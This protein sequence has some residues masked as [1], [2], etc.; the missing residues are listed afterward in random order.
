[1]ARPTPARAVIT[2]NCRPLGRLS[3]GLPPRARGS[4]RSLRVESIARGRDLCV[5]GRSRGARRSVPLGAVMAYPRARGHQLTPRPSNLVTPAPPLPPRARGSLPGVR[6]AGVGGAQAHLGARAGITSAAL[7]ST[8]CRRPTPARAG[9]TPLLYDLSTA[10]EGLPLRARGSP[11]CARGPN[12]GPTPAR[13][14]ITDRRARERRSRRGHP[15]AAGITMRETPGR[16][17]RHWPT[18]A[19]AGITMVGRKGPYVAG[20]PSPAARDHPRAPARELD[21]GAGLPRRGGGSRRRR[22]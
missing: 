12:R 2:V 10:H 7:S 19:C 3:C 15:C 18:L 8:S 20:G 14:G 4:P 5:R 16:G 1:M 21:A 9:I 22:P 17:C 13:A 11:G 6:C